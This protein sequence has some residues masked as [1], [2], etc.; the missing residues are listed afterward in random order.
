MF[1]KNKLAAVNSSRGFAVDPNWDYHQLNA[2]LMQYLP[3][4]AA[5]F[6]CTT[7][8]AN[9]EYV[10]GANGTAG[11]PYLPD[12]VLCARDRQNIIAVP[13]LVFPTGADTIKYS[14]PVQKMSWA[15]RMIVLCECYL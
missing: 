10:E 7:H 6:S 13:E 14:K 15:A 4:I 3:E 9:P 5:E 12:W 2:F 8:T 11:L 1:A